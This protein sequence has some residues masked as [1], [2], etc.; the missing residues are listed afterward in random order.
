MG[1][2][3]HDSMIQKE[4]AQSEEEEKTD[5]AIY[6]L[7]EMSDTWYSSSDEDSV[8][9]PNEFVVYERLGLLGSLNTNGRDSKVINYLTE[10]T[11]SRK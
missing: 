5:D 9:D 10:Y 6:D 8:Q 1:L 3:S 4:R 7:D 2:H 11:N